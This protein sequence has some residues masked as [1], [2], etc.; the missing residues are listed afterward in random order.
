MKILITGVSGFVGGYLTEEL[1][2]SS[3]KIEIYGTYLSE[4]ELA[5]LGEQRSAVKLFKCNICEPEEV[6]KVIK[7]I[8]PEQIY[9]LAGIASPADK[10][11]EKVLTVNIDGTV[12]VLRA[13]QELAKP[14][15]ILLASTGYVYG[16]ADDQQPFTE[17]SKLDAIGIYAESKLEMEKQALDFLADDLE[18]VISRAFNHIGPKQTPDFVASAFAK[19]IAEIEAGINSPVIYVGNLEATRDFLDVIDVVKAYRLMMEKA[20]SGE[21]YNVASGQ[22][23]KIAEILDKL[24]T[25]STKKISIEQ[26]KDRLRPSDLAYSVGNYGRIQKELGWQPTIPFNQTLQNVLDYWRQE[27]GNRPEN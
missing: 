1:S 20:N 23:I 5:N 22:A 19:Q 10:D 27:I 26:D 8:Q 16:S 7:E 12:N 3:E 25:L 2:S 6:E 21:I 11:K 18:I 17:E 13:C 14:V 15:R 24:L 4:G 9:H